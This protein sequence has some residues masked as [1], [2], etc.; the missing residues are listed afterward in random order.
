MPPGVNLPGNAR[1][2]FLN[3]L[4]NLQTPDGIFIPSVTFGDTPKG[5][6]APLSRPF[7]PLHRFVQTCGRVFK[8]VRRKFQQNAMP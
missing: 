2:K 6:L 7:Q 1:G 4:N 3:G 5:W 8:P